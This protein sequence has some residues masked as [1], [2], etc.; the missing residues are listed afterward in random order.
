MKRG[1]EAVA[2]LMLIYYK[3]KKLPDLVSEKDRTEEN[4]IAFL[5]RCCPNIASF[6]VPSL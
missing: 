2:K 5:E 3:G 1:A 6:F 4:E